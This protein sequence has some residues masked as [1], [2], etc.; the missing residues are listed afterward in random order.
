[1]ALAAIIFDLDGTLIDSAPDLR[2]AMNRVLARKG[3]RPLELDELKMMVGDGVP[4]LVERAF[5][6]TGAP[7][8][9]DSL[10]VLAQVFLDFYEGHGAVLTRPYPGAAEVLARLKGQGLKLALCTN[11]PQKATEAI[12]GQL[13]LAGFFDTVVGGDA[14]PAKKPDP[15]HLRMALDR[16]GVTT[17]STVMVGDGAA[18]VAAAR[19]A[20]LPVLV[21][22]HGYSRGVAP[23]ALGAD[24]VVPDLAALPGLIE[25]LS[26]TGMGRLP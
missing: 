13:G 14:P 15:A 4:K 2:T 7:L 23:E 18:D 10:T 1:M 8:D 5:A 20:G 24:G 21:M 22:A 11:K 25:R 9:P 6:T 17:A 26:L 19:A 3:R 12:I 16:L